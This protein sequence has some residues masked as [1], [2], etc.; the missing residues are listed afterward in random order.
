MR[1]EAQE[2]LSSEKMIRQTSEDV[3][4]HVKL[5]TLSRTQ[6]PAIRHSVAGISGSTCN[7]P[8]FTKSFKW[9]KKISS[10]GVGWIC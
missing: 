7:L 6:P 1:W 2:L 3:G 8:S 10:V 5:L 9:P 4:Q